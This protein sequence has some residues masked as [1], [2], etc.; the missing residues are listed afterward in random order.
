MT[1]YE[2]LAARAEKYLDLGMRMGQMSDSASNIYRIAADL[3]I[4]AKSQQ[5]RIEAL[6][7]RCKRLEEALI[8]YE[9]LLLINNVRQAA[10][11]AAPVWL[12]A[13][14]SARLALQ[15]NTNGG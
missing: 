4:C 11:D 10:K 13:A 1:E 3:L 7:A 15:E 9:R 14:D 6:E 5:A 8:L 2:E 12:E